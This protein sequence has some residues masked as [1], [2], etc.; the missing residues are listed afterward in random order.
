MDFVGADSAWLPANVQ[1][2]VCG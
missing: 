2:T 1:I